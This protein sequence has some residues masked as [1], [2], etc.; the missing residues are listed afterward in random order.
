V[1]EVNARLGG[2]LI[3]YLGALASGMDPGLA[4]AAVACGRRPELVADRRRVAAIRF[5]YPDRPDTTIAEIG[6]DRD[7]LPDSVDVAE[8]LAAPGA[9]VSP[10]PRGT[11]FGRIAL[12]TVAA[13]TVPQ[14]RQALAAAGSALRVRAADTGAVREGGTGPVPAA[15][16]R[17]TA[18]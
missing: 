1:I 14:C 11:L 6:F 16:E 9:V 8:P 2:D 18:G 5:F 4:A 17:A 12:A 10:P 13:D 3:P 7:A 15:S